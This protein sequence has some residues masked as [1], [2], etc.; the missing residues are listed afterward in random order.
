MLPTQNTGGFL[1]KELTIR[2]VIPRYPVC[3]KIYVL[4]GEQQYNV[5]YVYLWNTGDHM[6]GIS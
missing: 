6:L 3:S 1:I 5:H 4:S 2:C